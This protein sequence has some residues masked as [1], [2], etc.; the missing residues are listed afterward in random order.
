MK[1]HHSAEEARQEAEVHRQHITETLDVLTEKIDHTV[2]MAQERMSRPVKAVRQYPLA[3]IGSS[4]GAGF[5]LARL[6][7]RKAR[8]R[9]HEREFG[10]AEKLARAYFDGRQDEYRGRPLR[11]VEDWQQETQP[12]R[13]MMATAL[14]GLTLPLLKTFTFALG[15]TTAKQMQ[16]R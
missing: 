3:A 7:A 15:K 1:E 8:S 6:R 14:F 13:S 11:H 16:R 12:R 2:N 9:A 10:V 4:I 5:V